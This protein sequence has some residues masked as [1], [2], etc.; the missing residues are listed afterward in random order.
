MALKLRQRRARDKQDRILIDGQRELRAALSA[1]VVIETVLITEFESA[2]DE[3]NDTLQRCEASG[4][5]VL[6]VPPALLER[7]SY[8][9]R[10]D[11]PVA[12]AVPPEMRLADL[13]FEGT[14]LIAVLE[15]VEKPGNLGAIVRSADA[16]GIHAVIVADAGTDIFN[17]N[18][19]RASL[20]TIFT[21]P[22]CAA[23]ASEVVS[24]L[25]NHRIQP[26]VTR[27]DAEQTYD[28]YDF[29]KPTAIVLGSEAW[30]VSDLWKAFPRHAIRLPMLGHA[31]SLNVAATAAVLFYEANRQ[32]RTLN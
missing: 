18:A 11:Q 6:L 22:V 9:G 4:G 1:G 7:V 31:D 5:E 13:K 20:G 12:I 32:R 25:A 29:R 24:W 14:P 28:A 16:A 30:G 15:A 21:K 19:I 2:R 23:A 27:V 17:P 26:C 8:G 3:F 10:T